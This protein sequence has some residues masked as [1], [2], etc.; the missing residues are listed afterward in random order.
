MHKTITMFGNSVKY[1]FWGIITCSIF[2]LWLICDPALDIEQCKFGSCYG[3]VCRGRE[4]EHMNPTGDPE[5]KHSL[6]ASLFLSST[7]TP[8]FIWLCPDLVVWRKMTNLWVSSDTSC[9]QGCRS[10]DKNLGIT[11]SLHLQ[12]SVLENV[13]V[14]HCRACLLLNPGWPSLVC[15][16]NVAVLSV[17]GV[18]HVDVQDKFTACCCTADSELHSLLDSS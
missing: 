2:F 3:E 18:T 7:P 9:L 13:S 11:V 5:F 10:A 8:P 12:F 6:A 14:M 4:R 15:G 17:C 1:K 16:V